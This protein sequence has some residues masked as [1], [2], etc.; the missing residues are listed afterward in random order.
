MNK[1]KEDLL[2]DCFCDFRKDKQGVIACKE[3]PVFARS[4]DLVEYKVSTGELTAIEF[5]INDWKRAL[6]QLKNIEICFD[7]L[8]LCI[9]K[10]KTLKC[11]E[12]ITKSCAQEGIGLFLWD[13][14]DNTF[15]HKCIEKPRREIWD[16]QKKHIIDYLSNMEAQNE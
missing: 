8:V 16:I 6:A 4:V 1:Q 9:P 7:Y 11:V 13:N 10:P 3:V 5:K 12:T 15:L 14:N 2:R